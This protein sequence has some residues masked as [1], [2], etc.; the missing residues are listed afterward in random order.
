MTSVVWVKL[1][2]GAFTAKYFH[3]SGLVSCPSSFSWRQ[4]FGDFE[5]DFKGVGLVEGVK[6][7]Y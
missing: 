7:M 5:T 2:T 6:L 1:V 3:L 4:R